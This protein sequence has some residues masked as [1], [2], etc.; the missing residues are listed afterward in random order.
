MGGETKLKPAL[1][2]DRNWVNV[3]LPV[4]AKLIAETWF[5]GID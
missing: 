3:W 4:W 2:G 5:N 1:G